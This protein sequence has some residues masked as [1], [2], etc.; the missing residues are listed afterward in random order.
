MCRHKTKKLH[1]FQ[2]KHTTIVFTD[3]YE[4]F[5]KFRFENI[6]TAFVI[7]STKAA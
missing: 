6:F 5:A 1:N 4:M 3:I 7:E 2:L